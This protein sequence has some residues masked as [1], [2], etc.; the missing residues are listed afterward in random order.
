MTNGLY[1]IPEVDAELWLGKRV[2][3]REED[4]LLA[5]RDYGT[6]EVILMDNSWYRVCAPPRNQS[7]TACIFWGM[8]S[9]N[10]DDPQWDKV[11]CIRQLLVLILAKNNVT[12]WWCGLQ[13]HTN[14]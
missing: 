5:S 2:F 6:D 7:T 14:V 10:D 13:C 1:S 4:M 3:E 9:P 12:D 11:V 8:T